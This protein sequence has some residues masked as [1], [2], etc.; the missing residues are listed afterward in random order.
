[1]GWRSEQ[2]RSLS[3]RL[4]MLKSVGCTL[5]CLTYNGS[6]KSVILNIRALQVAFIIGV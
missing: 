1:M 3:F 5:P 6:A 2:N 4:Y